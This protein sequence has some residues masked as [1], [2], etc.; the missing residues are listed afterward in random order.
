MDEETATELVTQELFDAERFG[1]SEEKQQFETLEKRGSCQQILEWLGKQV[2]LLSS[3][4]CRS[5]AERMA[6]RTDLFGAVD[7]S[8]QTVGGSPPP[9][10]KLRR[11]IGEG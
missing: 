3:S 1:L 9:H 6:K 11:R 8:I 10:T 5:R 4:S 2:T 7:N